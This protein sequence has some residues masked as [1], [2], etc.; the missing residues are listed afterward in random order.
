MNAV[1]LRE[2]KLFA[3]QMNS[4]SIPSVDSSALVNSVLMAICVVLAIQS[5]CIKHAMYLFAVLLMLMYLFAF[6]SRCTLDRSSCGSNCSDIMEYSYS[7]IA[8]PSNM[9]DPNNQPIQ[10]LNLRGPKE[11]QSSI[12]VDL[13]I[14]VSNVGQ[15]L[16]DTEMQATREHFHLETSQETHNQVAVL[17]VK[18]LRGPQD[19]QLMMTMSTYRQGFFMGKSTAIVDLCISEYSLSP[20]IRLSG[21]LI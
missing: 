1:N 21:S 20:N 12:S 19:V 8:L 6:F 15:K 16:R 14:K 5:R 13:Q 2:M 17:I 3:D 4:V 18:P 7:V 11:P 9:K 10:L